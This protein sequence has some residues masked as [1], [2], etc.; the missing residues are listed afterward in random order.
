[1]LTSARYTLQENAEGSGY[2]VAIEM[3]GVTSSSEVVLDVDEQWLTL[4]VENPA[5]PYSLRIELDRPV[6]LRG[7]CRHTLYA[8][9]V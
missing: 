2:N 8:A 4:A 6:R 1:M 5:H 3:P 9:P 7:G